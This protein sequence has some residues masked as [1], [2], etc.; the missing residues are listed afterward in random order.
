MTTMKLPGFTAQVSV[1]RTETCFQRSAVL[2]EP[3]EGYVPRSV[4]PIVSRC[5]HDG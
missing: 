3:T 2:A 4:I 1:Y 5:A